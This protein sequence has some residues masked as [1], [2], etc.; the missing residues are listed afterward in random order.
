MDIFEKNYSMNEIRV[1]LF[2]CILALNAGSSA[3]E[4]KKEPTAASE[5]PIAIT[6]ARVRS[7]EEEQADTTVFAFA[8][9]PPRFPGGTEAMFSFIQKHKKYPQGG[10]DA[11]KEGKV[12][13]SF[14][15]Q[16]DGNIKNIIV[17]KSLSPSHDAEATRIIRKMPKW[18]PA[19][20]NGKPVN[21]S[22]TLPITFYFL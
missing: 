16:S 11:D 8:E 12:Y 10:P 20:Q 3:Q 15:V 13:V 4:K 9:Q 5:D 22:Y 6:P 19:K 18:I 17:K 21:C 1:L 2:C 7:P 14:V